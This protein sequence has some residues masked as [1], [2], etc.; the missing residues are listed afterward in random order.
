MNDT[1][2]RIRELIVGE[3]LLAEKY[4]SLLPSDERAA[5][6]ENRVTYA[7]EIATLKIS[8]IP[9]LGGQACADLET[10]FYKQNPGSQEII[11]KWMIEVNAKV[12][13]RF[14]ARS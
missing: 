4:L 7:D 1:I 3:V 12:M 8:I 10:E 11:K 13:D 14:F 9:N 6:E 2:R 5:H